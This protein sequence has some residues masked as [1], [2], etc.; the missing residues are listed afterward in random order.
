M[1]LS[2][3]LYSAMNAAFFS[4]SEVVFAGTSSPG[5]AASSLV[6]ELRWMMGSWAV[7]GEAALLVLI[8]MGAAVSALTGASLVEIGMKPGGSGTVFLLIN[9]GESG[10]ITMSV[11]LGIEAES[12]VDA[13]LNRAFSCESSQ[14]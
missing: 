14:A 10:S 2:P 1:E 6:A 4:F 9:S 5:V 13:L 3:L 12:W 7:M 8:S 11:S